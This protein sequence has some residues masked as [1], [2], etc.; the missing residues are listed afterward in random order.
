MLLGRIRR[1]VRSR[2]R[3]VSVLWFCW[4]AGT[5]S[6]QVLGTVGIESEIRCQNETLRQC[7]LFCTAL[8]SAHATHYIWDCPAQKGHGIG[9]A[10]GRRLGGLHSLY[11]HTYLFISIILAA[12]CMLPASSTLKCRLIQHLFHPSMLCSLRSLIEP[13]FLSRSQ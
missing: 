3:F 1:N 5:G 9:F 10:W 12:C 4:M 11:K 8:G 6:L 2:R 7:S 13:E